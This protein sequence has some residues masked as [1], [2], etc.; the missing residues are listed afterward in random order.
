M[1]A[2]EAN[3][4]TDLRRFDPAPRWR[5]RRRRTGVAVGTIAAA[6]AP[7]R[8]D[9][10]PRPHF[11]VPPAGSRRQGIRLDRHGHRLHPMGGA[12]RQGHQVREPAQGVV[13]LDVWVADDLIHR[14][15]V[16]S[17]WESGE[18]STIEFYDFGADIT[19]RPP[20]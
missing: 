3:P 7:Q 8:R 18:G 15:A 12:R 6:D 1:T 17:D 19:I 13:G 2:T 9:R 20:S 11:D 4:S 16:R 10:R 5:T 14:I